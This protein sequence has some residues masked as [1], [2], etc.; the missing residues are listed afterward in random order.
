MSSIIRWR[1]GDTLSSV[2][3]A[4][5]L[6]IEKTPIV[7]QVR[8][9]AKCAS[10]S[11]ARAISRERQCR[12]GLGS[13]YGERAHPVGA[14]ATSRA[15]LKGCLVPEAVS[16]VL[17]DGD[18]AADTEA[19]ATF[20]CAGDGQAH[21]VRA[22]T[23]GSSRLWSMIDDMRRVMRPAPVAVRGTSVFARGG[24]SRRCAWG[25]RSTGRARAG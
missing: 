14:T 18:I 10:L 3:G 2:M 21:L 13:R 22:G 4:S 24:K 23:A 8:Q 6:M 1:S 25:C 12:G 15:R 17:D 19:I 5:C 16:S 11:A 20:C 9:I 7:G